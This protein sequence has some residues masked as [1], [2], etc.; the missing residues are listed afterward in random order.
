MNE[1]VV[2]AVGLETRLA[3]DDQDVLNQMGVSCIRAI[4]GRGI[5]V[6]GA[7]TLSADA[8]RR[9]LSVRR[10]ANY[11]EESIAAGTEWATFEPNDEALR[12]RLRRAISDFLFDAWRTGA[13]VGP[14]PG[15]AF[16]VRCDTASE[17][18]DGTD[19]GPVVCEVGVAL[20]R[21]GEFWT[22]RL[23]QPAGDRGPVDG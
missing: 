19:A 5:V 1:V 16:F 13:L 23:T 4:P 9:H 14:T 2:G 11:L 8:A 6:W 18:G 7:R 12:A 15:D 21:P 22:F 10:T 3:R 20:V 17:P